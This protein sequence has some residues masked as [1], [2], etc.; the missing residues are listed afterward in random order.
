MQRNVKEQ[1][2]IEMAKK[3][4]GELVA[5]PNTKQTNG[6]AG[7]PDNNYIKD[8]SKI[9]QDIASIKQKAK[10]IKKTQN[11]APDT[12]NM[13]KIKSSREQYQMSLKEK[14]R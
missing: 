8:I 3:E 11:E 12:N 7:K 1:K 13:P 2:E 9:N 5:Q 10:Q 14:E 6:I 4:S